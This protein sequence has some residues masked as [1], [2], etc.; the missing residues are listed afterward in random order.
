[1][2]TNFHKF[3]LFLFILAGLITFSLNSS[4]VSGQVDQ[5]KIE[6]LNKQIAEYQAQIARL[7]S[8]ANTLSNQIAQ[9]DA[10]IALTTL[11]I[12][13][14]EDKILLLSGRINQ[15]QSSLT[16]LSEAFAS[17]AVETY[18]LTKLQE[19]FIMLL[20]SH[21]LATA[22]SSYHYLQKIQQSDHDLLVRLGNAQGTYENEKRNQ[23]DLQKEL[24]SQQKVLGAQKTAKNTLLA[25]T[26]NDEKRYQQLLN[27]ARSQLA[28]FSRFISS[29]GGASILTG[30]TRCDSWG[31]YYNQRDSEWGNLAIGNS[32]S[33]MAEFGCLITSMAMVTTHYGKHLKPSDIATTASVFFGNTAYM[34]QGSWSAS[35]V[36]TSRSRVCTNCQTSV[37]LQKIDNEVSAGRPVVVGL[38]SGPDHFIVLK[39]KS[40]NDYI[41][42]DPFLENGGDRMFSEKYSLSNIKTVDYVSVN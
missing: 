9:Y 20:T 28:A 27:E 18:K 26:K 2:T 35:G 17:R 39:A 31:C 13:Q 15:L 21:N 34:I 37:A 40:G 22:F 29:H 23:Q 4:N 42:N 33:S 1:M 38:F 19:P 11:K 25:Q 10:Q 6:E 8:E 7:N 3:I 30:Q 5:T 24:Q 14:T 12:S 41:M 32:N 16:A 36:T